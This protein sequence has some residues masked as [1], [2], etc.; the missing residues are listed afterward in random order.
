MPSHRSAC[1]SI[2]VSLILTLLVPLSGCGGSSS[3]T[4][5]SSS[6]STPVTLTY[7][8]TDFITGV[9]AL[10]GASGVQVSSAPVSSGSPGFTPTT[11]ANVINGGSR[12]VR[13]QSSS[14]FSIVYVTVGGVDRSVSGYWMLTLSGATTDTYIVITMSRS[15]PKTS[16]TTNISLATGTSQMT[17]AVEVS[18]TVLTAATGDVQVS[19]TW[20][21]ASDVDLQ[22]VEPGGER[23][24]WGHKTSAAGGALDLDSNASCNID[25]KNNENIRWTSAPAGSYTV[26]VDYYKAC[27]ATLTQYVVTVNNGGSQ[28]IYTGSFTGSGDLNVSPRTITTFTRGGP[29][30]TMAEAMRAV[31][32]QLAPTPP[33][34]L[35]R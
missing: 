35:W 4:S 22:V 16:F 21:T 27:T 10:S 7:S 28:G 34:P 15:M 31:L 5:P 29:L 24:Y 19:V 13:L 32:P 12:V 17:T 23:I 9:S 18:T 14:A 26:A 1:C 30:M 33:K 3:P 20:D 8:I 6:T 25:N 2:C 11:S